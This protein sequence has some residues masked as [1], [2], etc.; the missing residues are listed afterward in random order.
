MARQKINLLGWIGITG[1]FASIAAFA[2]SSDV[3]AW[4]DD[5]LAWTGDAL[6]WIW[7]DNWEAS[8][9]VVAIAILVYL[10]GRA[11]NE[12]KTLQ[13]EKRVRGRRLIEFRNLILDLDPAHPTIPLWKERTKVRRGGHVEIERRVDIEVVGPKPLRFWRFL[14]LGEPLSAKEQ[15]TV[16]PTVRMEPGGGLLDL[17]IEWETDERLVVFAD[18]PAPVAPQTSVSLTLNVAIPRALPRIW[19]DGSERLTWFSRPERPIRVLEYEIQVEDIPKDRVLSYSTV[20]LTHQPTV[21]HDQDGR[22]WIEGKEVGPP[23]H[24]AF[25]LTLDATRRASGD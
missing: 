14:V 17:Q 9:G 19:E 22:W 8:A 20:N 1:S 4:T 6:G 23:R 3:Q 5:A 18:L 15:K 13:E 16:H 11:Q 7:L 2:L 25:G 24:E 10:L 21:K 12:V